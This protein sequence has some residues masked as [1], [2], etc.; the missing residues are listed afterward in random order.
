[1]LRT[2]CGETF[3]GKRQVFGPAYTPGAR[4]V[5]EVCIEFMRVLRLCAQYAITFSHWH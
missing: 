3:I 5:M 1:M 2:A 4:D